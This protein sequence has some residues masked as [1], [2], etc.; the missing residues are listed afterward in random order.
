VLQLVEA[1]KVNLEDPVGN[2]VPDYPNRH[3]ADD[4]TIRFLMTHWGGPGDSGVLEPDA[5]DNRE[6][7]RERPDLVRSRGSDPV[8]APGPIEDCSNYGLT[9]LRDVVQRVTGQSYADYVEQH[10]FRAAG[11]T[12][13][14]FKGQSRGVAVGYTNIHDQLRAGQAA[15][16]WR[17]LPMSDGISTADDEIRFL[18]ALREG[19]LI[20]KQSLTDA[21]NRQMPWYGFGAGFNSPHLAH[22][23]HSGGAA[24]NSQVLAY[25]PVAD[26]TLVCLSNRD[27][28]VCDEAMSELH[29]ALAAADGK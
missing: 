18:T 28:Q 19:E 1:G 17:G 25:Y 29:A 6:W 8:C 16:P 9:L 27:P 7:T 22:W 26:L 11:M 14:S 12:Q 3:I 10:I 2:Y 4:V 13:T 24:G 20:S 5:I 23:G 21:I 15:L